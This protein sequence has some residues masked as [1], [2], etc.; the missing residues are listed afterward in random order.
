MNLKLDI[1]TENFSGELPTEA[2]PLQ[3]EL[4]ETT[5]SGVNDISSVE[6][7]IAKVEEYSEDLGEAIE[8]TQE[9]GSVQETVETQLEDEDYQ[10]LDVVS[11]ELLNLRL[12]R[13]QKK[14]GFNINSISKDI[15]KESFDGGASKRRKA[16][17]VANESMKEFGKTVWATIV[18]AWNVMVDTIKSI[19]RKWFTEQGR[20]TSTLQ[21]LIVSIRKHPIQSTKSITLPEVIGSVVPSEQ[22]SAASFL[23][24]N[25]DLNTITE[26]VMKS[27]EGISLAINAVAESY[28]LDDQAMVDAKVIEANDILAN[29][30]NLNSANTR[31]FYRKDNLGFN[32]LYIEGGNLDH[33]QVGIIK[34]TSGSRVMLTSSKEE[35]ITL[36]EELLGNVVDV[37]KITDQIDVADKKLKE[38]MSNLIK[39]GDEISGDD[40]SLKAVHGRDRKVFEDVIGDLNKLTNLAT[41]IMGNNMSVVRAGVLYIQTSLKE[42]SVQ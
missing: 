7:E 39:T 14:Y 33:Q 8:D 31:T 41:K 17:I 24:I 29:S 11:V 15:S 6:T 40:D 16:T 26:D 3:A 2:N 27:Y 1:S 37:K 10:G 32:G 9:I 13:M 23:E 20:L 30:V 36:A 22:V 18:K 4:T 28:T 34:L 25:K 12:T 5:L 21:K 19:F 42:G 35:L 38:S